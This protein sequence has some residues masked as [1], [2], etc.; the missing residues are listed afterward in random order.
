M[1]GYNTIGGGTPPT[2]LAWK[3]PGEMDSNP[4][5]F[6]N[7]GHPIPNGIK[8]G[9][10]GDCWFL[11]AVSSLAENRER[12][13]RFMHNRETSPKGIYR[14]YFWV[15]DGWYGINIDDRLPSRQW[16]RGWIPWAT[17]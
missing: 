6:G 14:F 4:K 9:S 3:R 12:V 1:Y 10:L 17:K 13:Y 7:I 2:S 16:G 11:A 8:Q 5:L 15:I